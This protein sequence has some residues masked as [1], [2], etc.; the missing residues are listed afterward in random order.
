MLDAGSFRMR[1]ELHTE[2]SSYTFFRPLAAGEPLDPEATAFDAVHPEWLAGIPG[3]LMVA[4]HVE[5]RSTERNQ[6][7]IGARQPVAERPHDGRRAGSPTRPPGFSPT[8]RSTTAFR[9]SSSSMSR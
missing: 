9:A 2:F 4:T 5:L 1:W 6:P 7:G 3:K 8:S